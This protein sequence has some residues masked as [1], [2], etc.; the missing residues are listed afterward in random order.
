[1]QTVNLDPVLKTELTVMCSHRNAH[2]I[3]VAL[4]PLI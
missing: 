3:G 4:V 1:M 2:A